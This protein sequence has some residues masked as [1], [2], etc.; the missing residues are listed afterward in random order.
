M[1]L[2]TLNFDHAGEDIQVGKLYRLRHTGC[3][4]V[5]ERVQGQKNLWSV[6]GDVDTNGVPIIPNALVLVVDKGEL[7]DFPEA[8]WNANIPIVLWGH[9]CLSIDRYH[10]GYFIPEP[11]ELSSE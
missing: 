4:Y 8:S 2:P 1:T 5:V 7:V 6:I 10:L 11:C 3:F 9:W